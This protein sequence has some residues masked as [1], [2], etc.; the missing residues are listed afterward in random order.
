MPFLKYP[1]TPPA[2]GSGE[3]IDSRTALYFGFV[4][5]SVLGVIGRG[6]GR[7]RRGSPVERRAGPSPAAA[8]YVVV[9]VVAA[10]AFPKVDELGAL[11]GRASLWYFRR[12]RRC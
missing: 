5:V 1:A 2:V 11:P 12:A 6:R 4:A 9:V 8:A 3:T 7:A 10:L